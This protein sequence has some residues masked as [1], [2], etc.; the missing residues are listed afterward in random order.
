[1]MNLQEAFDTMVRKVWE[2]NRPS[3]WDNGVCAYR[4]P[5]GTKCAVGHLI[6]RVYIF[7]ILRRKPR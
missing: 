7:H 5:N 3:T 2:Q 4:G 6:E 1:M